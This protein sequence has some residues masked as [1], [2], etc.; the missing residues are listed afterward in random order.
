MEYLNYRLTPDE[1]ISFN[2][3]FLKDENQKTPPSIIDNM[4]EAVAFFNH[5]LIQCGSRIE[6]LSKEH[7]SQYLDYHK[8]VD[9]IYISN[10][11][12][13]FINLDHLPNDDELLG[14]M[15]FCSLLNSPR[16]YG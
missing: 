7:L 14:I 10:I 4:P 16:F 12:R 13:G 5:A 15:N 3:L 11:V 2:T 9:E 1:V 6:R 8:N